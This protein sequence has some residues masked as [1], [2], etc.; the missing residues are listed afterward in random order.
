MIT[1]F[2][3]NEIGGATQLRTSLII[4]PSLGAVWKES[5]FSVCP[6]PVQQVILMS[7]QDNKVSNVCALCP[8]SFGSY[9]LQKLCPTAYHFYL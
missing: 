8:I 7:E 3:F 4:H 9:D 6:G 1:P 5:K 2:N